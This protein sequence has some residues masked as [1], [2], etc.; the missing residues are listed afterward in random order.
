M[1]IQPTSQFANDLV[2][3]LAHHQIYFKCFV[4]YTDMTDATLCLF[5]GINVQIG[6]DY[7]CV[8]KLL[9]N[10]NILFTPNCKTFASVVK[11]INKIHK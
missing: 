8:T 4:P 10:G 2:E 3:Y 6:L 7:M 9:D 5:N 1:I 11:Q